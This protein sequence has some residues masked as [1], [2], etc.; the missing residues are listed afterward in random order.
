MAKIVDAKYS[1][2]IG[3]PEMIRRLIAALAGNGAATVDLKFSNFI[4]LDREIDAAALREALATTPRK[5]PS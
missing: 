5:Q 1:T 3:T 2:L 4:V